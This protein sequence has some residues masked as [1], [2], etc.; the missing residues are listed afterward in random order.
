MATE[1]ATDPPPATDESAY[2]RYLLRDSRRILA[3]L[4]QLLEQRCTLTVAAADEAGDASA[5]TRAVS[6]LLGVEPDALWVDVP[7]AEAVL[8]R[9]LRC[10]RLA[11]D[12][13]LDRVHVRFHSGPPSLGRHQGYPALRL[14]IPES[15]LHLQRR[16]L[17]RRDPPPG[18][19]RCRLPAWPPE[20]PPRMIEATI[21]DIG[22]GGLAIVVPESSMGLRVGDIMRG[23]RIDVPES[24]PVEVD[25]EVCHLREVAQRAG[26][27]QQAGCRF[28]DLAPTAQSRLF[29]YLMQL[30]R[31]RLARR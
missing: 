29:R 5:A 31:E 26:P 27:V 10:E 8:Q 25:L 4:Q 7:R 2:E 20:N 6:A 17:M 1:L 15:I 18:T 16:E 11:L 14:P 24:G 9:L 19:L 21:R 3:L 28:V 30:D 22:G 13:Q 12:G 23:C